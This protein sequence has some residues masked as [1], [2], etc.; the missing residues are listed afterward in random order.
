MRFDAPP[1]GL[2]RAKPLDPEGRPRP[3]YESYEIKGE[4][5]ADDENRFQYPPEADETGISSDPQEIK[6]GR[7]AKEV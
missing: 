1:F 3:F 7:A 2:R 4:I 5:A 6:E